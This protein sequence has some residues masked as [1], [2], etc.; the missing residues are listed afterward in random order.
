VPINTALIVVDIQN[1]TFPWLKRERKPDIEYIP[2]QGW[3]AINEAGLL[4]FGHD[5]LK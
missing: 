3:Q 4:A 2:R 1:D 5:E